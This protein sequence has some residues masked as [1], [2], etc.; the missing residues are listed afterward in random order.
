MNKNNKI[1]KINSLNRNLEYRIRDNEKIIFFLYL[2]GKEDKEG[3]LK[4]YLEGKN[5]EVKISGVIL[6]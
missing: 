2:I 1:I 3:K 4:I 5:S 6:A